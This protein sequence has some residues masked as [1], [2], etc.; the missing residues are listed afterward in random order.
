MAII[1]YKE[2]FIR[3]TNVV[4]EEVDDPNKKGRTL[5]KDEAKK[6]IKELGLV[7][8]YSGDE[9]IIW[10]TPEKFKGIHVKDL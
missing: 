8:V 3:M 1:K 5:S 2:T 6:R 9:G 10:D 7:K 4:Y